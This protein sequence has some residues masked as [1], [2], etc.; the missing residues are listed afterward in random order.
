MADALSRIPESSLTHISGP[1]IESLDEIQEEVHQDPVLRAIVE[2]LQQGRATED[3][4]HLQGTRLYY[5]GRLVLPATSPWRTIMIREFHASPTGGHAGILRTL[6]RVRANV[7]WKGMRRDVQQFVRECDICQRQKYETTSPAG[8]LTPLEIPH[9]IWDTVSMDFIEGLPKS[10]GKSV[11]LVVVDKLSK[12]GHFIALSHPY[13]GETVA[14]LF[15]KEIVRL[16]GIPR[17]II[18]DRDAVFVSNFWTELFRLQGTSL[19]M[20][21]ANHPQTDGQTEVLNRGVETYL[22]C[23]V[24]DEPRTWT[25]WL[26]WAEYCYNTSFHTASKL[27]PFEAVYGR[28]PPMLCSYEPADRKSVV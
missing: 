5:Q 24:M 14:E 9:Q 3:G 22:R 8:L 21:T 18:S 28:L 23:F 4:Y 13:S 25:R 26:H 6:Q 19:R 27:T 2:A 20:S 17:A 7:F 15:A 11:I 1:V 10:Q 16:H 12:Y